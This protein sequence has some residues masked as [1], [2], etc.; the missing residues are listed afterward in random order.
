MMENNIQDSIDNSVEDIDSGLYQM[1]G[2]VLVLPVNKTTSVPLNVNSSL[3]SNQSSHHKW[4]P[5]SLPSSSSA[6]STSTTSHL[7]SS[8]TSTSSA[9]SST[10]KFKNTSKKE[11]NNSETIELQPLHLTKEDFVFRIKS[12]LVSYYALVLPTGKCITITILT[13]FML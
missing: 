6:S 11:K 4:K 10:E 8:S 9:A 7:K 13:S 1:V 12:T 3:K 5:V 2:G